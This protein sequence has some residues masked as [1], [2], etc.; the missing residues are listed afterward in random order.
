VWLDARKTSPYL[1]FQ[2]WMDTDDIQVGEFLAKFTLLP[3]DEVAA[4]TEA[5]A[6][7]PERHEGQRR[8]AQEVTALVHGD[9][10][11]RAAEEASRVLF[12][13]SPADAGPAALEFVAREVPTAP[14]PN[15]A[16]LEAGVDIVGLLVDAG[17]ASSNSDAR[18]ALEQGAISVNGERAAVGRKV[19]RDDVRHGRYVVLR[20]GKKS[21]AVLVEDL[22]S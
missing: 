5:H 2:H 16:E 21:Y 22:G 20:K 17:L 19:G 13:G 12:G 1:F 4:L 3:M 15:G 7:A 9:D 10:A 8:L 6:D 11:A 14:L 18:R